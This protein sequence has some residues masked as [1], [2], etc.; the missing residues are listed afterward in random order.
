[1]PK[2]NKKDHNQRYLNRP[3]HS[4]LQIWEL[5]LEDMRADMDQINLA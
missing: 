4:M 5:C 3:K 2:Y 1:M